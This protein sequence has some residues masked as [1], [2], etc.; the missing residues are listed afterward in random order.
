MESYIA[1]SLLNFFVVGVFLVWFYIYFMSMIRAIMDFNDK[2]LGM[3]QVKETGW[4]GVTE[5][6]G[7]TLYDY[8]TD[9]KKEE[10]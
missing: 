2:L 10:E 8:F 4:G 9:M 6:Q 1:L 5:H 3:V 7:K